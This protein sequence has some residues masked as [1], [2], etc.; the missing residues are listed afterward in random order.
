MTHLAENVTRLYCFD[1]AGA[2]CGC[3]LVI[4]LLNHLGGPQAMLSITLLACLACWLFPSNIPMRGLTRLLLPAL[5]AFSVVLVELG[6]P[7]H[8]LLKIRHVKGRNEGEPLFVKW[9]SFSRITVDQVNRD[10][11][12]TWIIMDG[13]A[14]TILPYLDGNLAHWQ[15][16]KTRASS[17]AY[18]L[19]SNAESLIIG[20]GGGIDIL[21]ALLFGHRDITGV[22]I[23]PITVND[24]MRGEFREFTGYLYFRPEVE[25][26]VDE[27]RSFI[28]KTDRHFDIIQATLVDTW[29]ATAAGAFALT[30]NNLYTVEA[31]K[32]YLYKLKPDGILTLTRWNLE[33]PQQDLRLVSL[34]REAMREL[35][36]PHPER[37]IMVV[38]EPRRREAVECALLFKKSGFTNHEIQIVEEVSREHSLDLLYTPNTRPDNPFTRLIT[39]DNPDAFYRQYPYD[40]SPTRDNSPF[41]FH[42]A[43]LSQLWNSL[44]LTWE[45]KKTNIGILVL[46]LVFLV[47]FFLVVLLIVIPLL[48]LRRAVLSAGHDLRHLAYFICLGLGFILIEMTLVQKF[49]LFL[50][51]PVYALGV[52][53]FSILLFSGFGS[54][55]S[56]RL[57]RRVSHMNIQSVCLLV[58]VLVCAYLVTLPYFLYKFVGL[59]I[60]GRVVLSVVLL[61][62]LSFIL[63]MPMPMGIKQLRLASPQ[64][65]PWA[66]GMN[67]SAS[68]LGSILTV[69]IAVNFGFNQALL[70]AMALYLFAAT[71]GV[72]LARLEKQRGEVR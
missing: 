37:S 57:S 66:W 69:L 7:N 68:V 53:L 16:L 60:S 17:L 22:E 20:P 55:L 21:T 5:L 24:I 45:S 51:Q 8:P 49:I 54:L 44:Y 15:F 61:V 42:T 46:F 9:N 71:L 33:P 10:P 63:G 2:A 64:L 70:V 19:K 30:E 52:V 25:I 3:I 67:G 34:T 1:L 48:G 58:A 14:G 65:I 28:R 13:D 43:R 47:S 50:G 26:H 41:F 32:D 11:R 62:P 39:T 12:D 35:H 4:P 40:V 72:G 29:A 23:N 36:L 27:G 56:S 18:R 31:F 38:R 59:S 6:F